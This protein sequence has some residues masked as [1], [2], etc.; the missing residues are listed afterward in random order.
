METAEN[1]CLDFGCQGGKGFF[2][3]VSNFVDKFEDKF[4]SNIKRPSET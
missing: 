2:A 4:P 3:K 1:L